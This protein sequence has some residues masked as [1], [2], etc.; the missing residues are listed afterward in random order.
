MPHLHE[1]VDFCSEVFI[2]FKNK[3]LLRKH[4]K[5]KIWLSVGG[6]IEL[7]EDPEQAAIREVKEEVGLVVSLFNEEDLAFL[8]QEGLKSLIRPQYVSRHRI[9]ENHEHVAFVFFAKAKTDKLKLSDSE[10]SDECRWFSKEDLD[11][12]KYSIRK[13]IRFY[14]LKALETLS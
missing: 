14:A 9:N 7:D 2:V 12:G 4:D 3:V 1:K 8:N 6:H 10:K 13:E 5:L 11:S